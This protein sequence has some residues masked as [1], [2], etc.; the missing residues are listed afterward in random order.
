MRFVNIILK[1]PKSKMSKLYI[2]VTILIFY[3]RAGSYSVSK[4]PTPS[5]LAA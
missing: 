3:S 4:I 2:Y 1:R 5:K